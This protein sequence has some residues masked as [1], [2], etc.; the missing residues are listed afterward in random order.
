MTSTLFDILAS[1]FSSG[2]DHQSPCESKESS[3]CDREE[4]VVLL[5]KESI[6]ALSTDEASSKQSRGLYPLQ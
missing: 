5:T 3:S 2:G 1:P 4:L 6:Y